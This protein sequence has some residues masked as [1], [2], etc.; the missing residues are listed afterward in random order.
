MEMAFLFKKYFYQIITI[1]EYM[2]CLSFEFGWLRFMQENI[3]LFIY[4]K[5][6][7]KKA[8]NKK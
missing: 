1:K 5:K 3:D 4:L 6:I 2:F 7:G 8:L